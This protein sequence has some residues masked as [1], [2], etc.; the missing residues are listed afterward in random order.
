MKGIADRRDGP[1][2]LYIFDW[3]PTDRV[4]KVMPNENIALCSCNVLVAVVNPGD[5]AMMDWIIRSGNVERLPCKQM[6]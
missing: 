4:W 3:E 2:S 5:T 6:H 1:G